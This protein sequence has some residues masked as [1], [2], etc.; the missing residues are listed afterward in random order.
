[1]VGSGVVGPNPINQIRVE[2]V[3]SPRRLA[4]EEAMDLRYDDFSLH[5]QPEGDEIRLEA[6]W[7]GTARVE[8]IPSARALLGAIPSASTAVAFQSEMSPPQA[9][10]NT[11]VVG[12]PWL[13]SP[14][15]DWAEEAGAYLF[16][17]IF[18]GE[19]RSLFDQAC[20]RRLGP[21][22]GLRIRVHFDPA[23]TGAA[24]LAGVPW[25]LLYREDQ[26]DFLG[27]SSLTPVV[28][29]LDVARP[30]ALGPCTQ[31]L[32]VLVV[33]FNPP[34]TSELHLEDEERQV[35]EPL[36]GVSGIEARYLAAAD[37]ETLHEALCRSEVHALHL[38]GHGDFDASSGEGSLLLEG[39]DVG[40]PLG[41]EVLARLVRD[42]PPRLV[43]ANA[44][45]TARQ[46]HTAPF[47]GVAAAL[48]L[49][50]VPAVVAMRDEIP[51]RAALTFAKTLYM[52]LARGRPLEAAV[53]EGRLAIYRNDPSSLDWMLPVLFLRVAGEEIFPVFAEPPEPNGR[54][55]EMESP[56][57]TP[58]PSVTIVGAK[59]VGVVNSGSGSKNKVGDL[60][61]K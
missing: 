5:F 51:N 30:L 34:A 38:M 11:H 53:A 36:T 4:G 44:C 2:R 22:S 49:A 13:P 48:V 26:K 58:T 14:P 25:E 46:G 60:T 16:R 41:G 1:V 52:E 8:R 28:R 17:M 43:V 10:R 20:G 6:R 19:V 57:A 7:S 33:G 27:L 47:A 24:P 50:G 42:R 54:D 23:V 31:P 9:G 40:V 21:G 29:H 45:S 59:Q 12:S 61:F 18:K 3:F 35:K 56:F 32:Q 39:S 37:A 15:S 55:E